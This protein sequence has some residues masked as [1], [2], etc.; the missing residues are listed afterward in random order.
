MVA[1]ADDV[2]DLP[3]AQI[4]PADIGQRGMEA[5]SVV[6]LFDEDRDVA[7]RM[8]QIPIA[9]RINLFPFECLHKALA[10]GVVVGIGWLAHVRDHVMVV[11][12][13]HVLPLVGCSSPLK[14]YVV[15]YARGNDATA[16]GS[17]ERPCQS[18]GTMPDAGR[19]RR[20]AIVLNG[21][22]VSVTTA[23]GK[24]KGQIA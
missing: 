23:W 7:T 2:T 5:R 16:Q 21:K 11:K 6:V 12:E 4:P 1:A 9:V 13:L 18:R 24:V 15:D 17:R 10:A 22:S 19:A 20:G 3:P 14:E 8:P